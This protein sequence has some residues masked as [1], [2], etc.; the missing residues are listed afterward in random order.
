M[1]VRLHILC[2][3]GREAITINGG[4]FTNGF[5]FETFPTRSIFRG[6]IV[7]VGVFSG[8]EEEEVGINLLAVEG[9]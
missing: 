6:N 9:G 5:S 3:E 4:W 7:E 8:K 2:R 1:Q